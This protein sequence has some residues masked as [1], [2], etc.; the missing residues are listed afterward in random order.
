MTTG[1]FDRLALDATVIRVLDDS[2]KIRH[3]EIRKWC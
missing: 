1:M 2:P 3:V